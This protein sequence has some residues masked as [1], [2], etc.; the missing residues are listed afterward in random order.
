MKTTIK[1][2]SLTPPPSSLV[3][4]LAWGLVFMML[5]WSWQGAEIRPMALIA[6][7]ANMA[8]F[9]KEFFPPNFHDWRIYLSEMVIT[10]HIASWGTVLVHL[11]V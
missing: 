6:D 1:D 8:V 4:Q 3:T 5:I 11:R 7:S 9:S 10:V 2:I